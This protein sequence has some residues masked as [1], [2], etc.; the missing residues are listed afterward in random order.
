MDL[1]DKIILL[2]VALQAVHWLLTRLGAGIRTLG[3]NQ[4][5]PAP[6]TL[7]PHDPRVA[8]QV[9]VAQQQIDD[10]RAEAGRLYD[11]LARLERDLASADG[12]V[13][14]L[15]QI[16][17]E[18]TLTDLEA[19]RRGLDG[20]AEHLRAADLVAALHFLQYRD[21]SQ[22]F[23]ALATSRH[24]YYVLRAAAEWRSD[25]QLA[26]VM[27]DGDAIAAA[28]LRP[29]GDFCGAHGVAFPRQRPI[30]VPAE[31]GREAVLY[32][33]LPGHPVIFVPDDFG[34][35]L[36][37]WSSLGH[38]VGHV[39]W[40]Y[41]PGF[42]DD[43]EALVPVY[44]PAWLPR[45]QG[46]QVI[47][48][49][50]AAYRAWLPELIADAF[51]ALMLGP[52]ALRGMMH[53][54]ESPSDPTQVVTVAG[55]P[56]GQTVGS[57]P[58]AHLRVVLT[59]WLLRRMGYGSRADELVRE[60]TLAHGSP[61]VIVLP[62]LFGQDVVIPLT[63]VTPLGEYV[64]EQFYTMEYDSLGGYPLSA[65]SGLEM[66]P[67]VWARVDRR[68]EQL[69]EDHPFN[70]D[71]RV[72]IA[73]GITAAGRR[74]GAQQRIARGVRRAILG[75]DIKQRR[76]VDPAYAEA[77]DDLTTPLSPAEVLDAVVLRAVLQRRRGIER[78]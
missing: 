39:M 61:E 15:R 12:P 52:A 65:V 38:E 62:S 43:V 46:R 70:D 45:L 36:L 7:A 20:A 33:L 50:Q 40:A 44:E 58:P 26:E 32:E 71:P 13:A 21:L 9:R 67:G 68:A 64:Y 48:N 2:V 1:F 3:E 59:G 14:I 16:I 49:L 74:P 10:A 66:T 19:A 28:L 11:D 47:F 27:A 37:R 60:W 35:D 69:I 41:V 24:R 6:Q 77:P 78:L 23:R 56:D 30:C 18:P 53:A 22:E 73:A 34:E 17:N 76:V 42:G 55:A 4:K 75:L 63:R 72:V 57:H 31:R 51:A 29:L 5:A 8:S 25:R 54:F